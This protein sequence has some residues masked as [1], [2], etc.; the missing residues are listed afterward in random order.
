MFDENN[1]KM[2][3]NTERPRTTIDGTAENHREQ[4]ERI[5]RSTVTNSRKEKK[6]GPWII[7]T[8]VTA[9]LC[10]VTS[11]ATAKLVTNDLLKQMEDKQVV[12]Y[13]NLNS[14]KTNVSTVTD[15]SAVVSEIENT[16]VEVYTETVKH[17]MFYGDYVTSGAGSGVIITEDG[18]IVTNAHVINDARSIRVALHD[19]S[20]YSAV[21]IGKDTESDLAVLKIDK[22]G[23]EPAVLGSS[24]T[25]KVGETCIAIGNPLGTLGGTVTSGMVSALSREISVEGNKM[26]LLQTDTTINPG[27]S[28]GGLFNVSG[29]LI[30]IVNSKY[31]SESIEGIGFAIPIDTVKEI[32]NELIVNGRVTGRAVLGISSTSIEN[33]RYQNYYQV[34]QNGVYVNEV[35]LDSTYKAGLRSGDL[36]IQLDDIKIESYDN[37]KDALGKYKAG[38]SVT[39]K[40]VRN[41]KTIDI[42]VVL[43]EKTE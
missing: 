4:D 5:Y 13:Q 11:F 18:Y 23:L 12:I 38:D 41:N 6:A 17:S 10:G 7:W 21:L 42:R 9:L 39:I 32:I 34:D 27:N 43:A 3:N 33:E 36:I 37:L 26:T 14:E 15:L 40:V 2:N 35:T 1:E 8:I 30:G 28:G 24:S 19:G 25:L 22:S 20:D 31:S 29:E 16:V